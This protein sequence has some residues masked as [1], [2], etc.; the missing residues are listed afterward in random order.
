MTGQ[1]FDYSSERQRHEKL[2]GRAELL[3]H[4]DQLLVGSVPSG[5][6]SRVRI[7]ARVAIVSETWT[8]GAT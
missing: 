1:R 6:S 2:V 8:L 3:A 4:L 5:V 7:S